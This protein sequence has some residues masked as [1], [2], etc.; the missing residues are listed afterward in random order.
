M[1]SDDSSL[2][3]VRPADAAALAASTTGTV[4]LPGDA[5]YDEERAVFNLNHELVPALIV[6]ARGAADVQAAV[7]FAARQ[8]RPVLVKTTG[9]Q[10]V[11]PARGA[12]VIATHL[13]NDIAVDPAARTARVGAGVIW[14]RSSRRRP[15]RGWPR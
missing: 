8:Q 11:G 13:M 15:R 5:G 9:H 12:V 10:M 6:V 3:A 2:P 7:G 1:T 14:S 4:L